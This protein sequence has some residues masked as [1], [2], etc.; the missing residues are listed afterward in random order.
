LSINLN[1]GPWL[2]EWL[3]P[4]GEV[5]ARSDYEKREKYLSF[6]CQHRAPAAAAHWEYLLSPLVLHHSDRP[7]LVRYRQLEYYRMPYMAFFAI[8]DTN[9]L[10]RPDLIRMA[11]GNE[12]GPSSELPY[13]ASYLAEM[14][15]DAAMTVIATP[16]SERNPSGPASCVPV[17]RWLSSVKPRIASS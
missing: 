5:L 1:G 13:S 7:G 10:T 6:A 2:V 14:R 16:S 4:E 3:S 11:I 15:T 12:A 8:E 9:A 17:R